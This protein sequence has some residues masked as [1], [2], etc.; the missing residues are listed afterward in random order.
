MLKRNLP[1][2][3]GRLVWRPAHGVV[4]VCRAEVR[5]VRGP[6]TTMMPASFLSWTTRFLG[7]V[8]SSWNIIWSAGR[9][10]TAGRGPGARGGTAQQDP[11]HDDLPDT[12][13]RR[14]H[15]PPWRA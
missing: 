11:S 8:H 13:A 12:T 14:E 2:R 9:N 6:R 10:V 3:G 4:A 1:S 7:N 15:D 5:Y